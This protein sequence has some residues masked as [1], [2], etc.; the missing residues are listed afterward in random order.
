MSTFD[1]FSIN[2]FFYWSGT[3]I[4]PTILIILLLL[5]FGFMAFYQQLSDYTNNFH[6]YFGV[7]YES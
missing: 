4:L 1:Y 2:V 5:L 6:N 3:V 7:D